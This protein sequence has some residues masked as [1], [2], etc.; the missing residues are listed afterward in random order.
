[1]VSTVFLSWATSIRSMVAWAGTSA[2][3]HGFPLSRTLV[4]SVTWKA[5]R[6]PGSPAETGASGAGREASAQ[7]TSLGSGETG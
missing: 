5:D 1:M 3:R 2:Y 4:W 6:V 7:R